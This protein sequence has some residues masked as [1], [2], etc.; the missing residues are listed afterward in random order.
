MLNNWKDESVSQGTVFHAKI[1]HSNKRESSAFMELT[2]L[3]K[4]HTKEVE[5]VFNYNAGLI[6]YPVQEPA[7]PD[8]YQ[9]L[10]SSDWLKL[11]TS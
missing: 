2:I 4:H 5:N 6:A 8:F 1:Y 3:N 11:P 9:T 10:L 7:R